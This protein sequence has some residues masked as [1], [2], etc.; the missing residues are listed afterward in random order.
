MKT[1]FLKAIF[2]FSFISILIN[3]SG[4]LTS[5]HAETY[6]NSSNWQ[7]PD[8]NGQYW[9]YIDLPGTYYLATDGD[10]FVTTHNHAIR[11]ACSDVILDGSGKTITGSA[12]AP[13]VSETAPDVYG[14]RVNT[15]GVATNVTVKNLKVE[16]KYFGVIFEQASN[17]TV[18]DVTATNNRQG[19]YLWD[20]DESTITSNDASDN[21][22]SGIVF[23]GDNSENNSNTISN[24]ITNTNAQFGILLWLHCA[25]STLT[26]NT[27]NYNGNSGISISNNVSYDGNNILTGNTLNNNSVSGL[28]IS[29]TNLNQISSN[30]CTNNT[31]S[32]L[33]L[34]SSNQNTIENNINVTG[35]E[36][37]GIWLSES[38]SNTFTSNTLSSNS[39]HGI[40]LASGSSENTLDKNITNDNADVGITIQSTSDANILTEHTANNNSNGLKIDNSDSTKIENGAFKDNQNNGV[41]IESSSGNT[42][43]G[44]TVTGNY[45]AGI[46]LKSSTNNSILRN[47]VTSQTFW[48]IFLDST[49]GQ[50]IYNNNFNNANGNVGF[51]GDN[52]DNIWNTS[53]TEGESIMGGPF[54][55]GNFWGKPDGTGFSETCTDSNK[56]GICDAPY[57][58]GTN[59]VD[60]LPLLT[61][62]FYVNKNDPN[63]AGRYS[64]CYGTIQEA[65]DNANSGAT[66]KI[67]A[68][69]YVDTPLS[70]VGS[71][72][73]SLE[74]G[75]DSSF[76]NQTET[77][78]T[79]TVPAV[80]DGKIV[81]KN[82]I[83]I[84]PN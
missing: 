24:N 66:I 13:S 48:G 57:N 52:T 22:D 39:G 9:W 68:G 1:L 31:N 43:E 19:I 59:N 32:G 71:K 63:C 26:G 21:L 83:K 45:N 15:A 28:Y 75:W 64:P 12:P 7:G 20:V 51:A 41:W 30:T 4:H 49:S 46:F 35:N 14:V 62:L 36:V 10:T 3:G 79:I 58:I 72:T 77:P 38:S 42:I 47:A 54:L 80:D 81:F 27:A 2:F 37:A 84:T 55:G 73:I 76:E 67:T 8:A 50:I 5:A 33:A 34:N 29:N 74:G 61:Y 78:T 53:K 23:D 56:D 6:L 16:N 18:E 65:I 60:N 11:I 70:V 44:N 69:D 40:A 25:N 17:A 82:Y